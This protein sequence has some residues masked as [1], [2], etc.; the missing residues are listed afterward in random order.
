MDAALVRAVID[1]A[2]SGRCSCKDKA[3][4]IDSLPFDI[5]VHIVGIGSCGGVMSMWRVSRAWRHV[6]SFVLLDVYWP[7][8]NQY[9]RAMRL[10]IIG[11]KAR[12]RFVLQYVTSEPYRHEAY[13]PPQLCTRLVRHRC[14]A[15]TRCG[16]RCKRVAGNNGVCWQHRGAHE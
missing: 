15:N 13:S 5:M 16:G 11:D 12:I 1:F 3:M 7:L 8:A 9:A 2:Y 10:H 4:S 6:S 14:A